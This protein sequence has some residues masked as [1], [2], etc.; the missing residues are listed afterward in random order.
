M[1][2]TGGRTCNIDSLKFKRGHVKTKMS[3]IEYNT[4]LAN[5]R[6]GQRDN[7]LKEIEQVKKDLI[8]LTQDTGDLET[9]G[10]ANQDNLR[11]ATT[12]RVCQ[13]LE[14][15]ILPSAKEGVREDQNEAAIYNTEME[16][17]PQGIKDKLNI[18]TQ[19]QSRTDT[20]EKEEAKIRE[21]IHKMMV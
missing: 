20:M 7:L 11:T 12:A 18:L 10:N 14:Q 15:N 19:I 6:K 1:T 9:T 21:D 2:Q 16:L 17:L 3:D 8:Q 4:N 13:H 5:S